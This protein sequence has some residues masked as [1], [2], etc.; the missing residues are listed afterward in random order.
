VAPHTDHTTL[1]KDAIGELYET[2]YERVVRYIN[3]RVGDVAEAENLASEVFVRALRNAD[4]FRDTG[5]PLEAWVF[6]IARNIAVDFLRARGRR[7]LSSAIDDD[8]LQVRSDD[9]PTRNAERR[10]DL[11][12][13]NEAMQELTDAQRQVLSLRFVGQMTSE[14]VARVMGR[15]PGAVREMQSAAIKKLREV[16]GA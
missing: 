9:D 14:E 10:N 12:M 16:L 4:S 13:L 11:A 2:H 3:V 7:P 15:K 8:A 1:T 5:A 6:R